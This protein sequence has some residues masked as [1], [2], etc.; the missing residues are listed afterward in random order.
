MTQ[1]EW[2]PPDLRQADSCSCSCTARGHAVADAILHSR[3][4]DYAPAP[5]MKQR[6]CVAPSAS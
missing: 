1:R 6:I 5:G 2:L 4:N 3:Q